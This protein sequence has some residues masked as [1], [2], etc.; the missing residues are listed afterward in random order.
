MASPKGHPAYNIFGESGRPP[1]YT[2]E[3]I[4]NQADMLIEWLKD[5]NNIFFKDFLLDQ[6]I[7]PE[8]MALWA[9]KNERFSVAYQYAKHKQESKL[10]KGALN[11]GYDVGFT[12]FL[13]VNNHG[14]GKYSD[15]TETHTT[16][17]SK[18]KV[19]MAIEDAMDTSKGLIDD[20]DQSS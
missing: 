16:S 3:F 13:L 14:V 17:E 9:D 6:H 15:K 20:E 4:N 5:D 18:T 11:K 12:K 2:E 7:L 19:V 1:I 10:K 8:N